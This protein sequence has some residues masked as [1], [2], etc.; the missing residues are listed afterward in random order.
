VGLALLSNTLQA[1][2]QPGSSALV[3]AAVSVVGE[4]AGCRPCRGWCLESRPGHYAY[5][6]ARGWLQPVGGRQQ[7]AAALE[8]E[9]ELE[10]M[11]RA[12]LP[13]RWSSSAERRDPDRGG[14]DLRAGR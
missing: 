10:V 11:A 2:L 5:S 1:A 4:T 3:G 13:R 9:V 8:V 12:S 14:V 7:L 6:P